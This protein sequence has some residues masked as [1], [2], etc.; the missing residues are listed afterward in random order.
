[1]SLDHKRIGIMYLIATAAFFLLGS[2][3]A[4]LLHLELMAPGEM[5]DADTYSQVFT[6][7]GAIMVFLFLIPSI[8]AALGNFFLPLMVQAKGLAYPKLNRTSFHIYI[9]GSI[10][11]LCRFFSASASTPAGPSTTRATTPCSSMAL[12]VFVLS[13]SSFL[14]R[15]EL[16]RDGAQYAWPRRRLGPVAA[17]CLGPLRHGHRA[18]HR[19]AP[20]RRR[21]RAHG[22]RAW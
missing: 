19:D 9:V 20:A 4:L 14:T 5:L 7:H 11:A 15:R 10:F 3:L 18:G 21:A 8:P 12:A 2:V 1:M 16:H 17:L 6:L 22:R 13:L